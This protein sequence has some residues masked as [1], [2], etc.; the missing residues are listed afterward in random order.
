MTGRPLQR[1]PIEISFEEFSIKM[2]SCLT[3]S[4]SKEETIRQ[5]YIKYLLAQ[6]ET[7]LQWIE[8]YGYD[9]VEEWCER[10]FDDWDFDAHSTILKSKFLTKYNNIMPIR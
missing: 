6:M 4:F 1:P 3:K 9:T 2:N 7:T 5:F 8:K 10:F